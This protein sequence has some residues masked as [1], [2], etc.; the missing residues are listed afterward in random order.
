MGTN[1]H[2]RP[3]QFFS[4][5]Q[6]DAL[7]APIE[8]AEGLPGSAYA[9]AEFFELEKRELWPKRWVAVAFTNDI[10]EPGS[11]TTAN[12]A[13]VPLILARGLDGIARAFVNICPHRAN[14]LV[15]EPAHG[16]RAITCGW[17]CWTFDLEGKFIAAPRAKGQ[18]DAPTICSPPPALKAVRATEWLGTIFVNLGGNAPD[19]EK[20][21]EAL[22]T[23]YRAWRSL[24]ELVQVAEVEKTWNANWKLWVEGGIEDYHLQFVHPQLLRDAKDFDSKPHKLGD[25]FFGLLSKQTKRLNPAD[26]PP[27]PLPEF[28][29]MPAEARSAGGFFVMFPNFGMNIRTTY[30][31]VYFLTPEAPDRTRGR[32]QLLALPEALGDARYQ[33][34]VDRLRGMWTR[35]WDEDAPICAAVQKSAEIRDRVGSPTRFV[36]GWEDSVRNF[37]LK[38]V[39]TIN[40]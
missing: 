9:S 14:R 1:G 38:V 19:L 33:P 7:S 20:Q 10:L 26:I 11:L 13:D 2:N 28:P 25:D 17:H 29:G 32:S 37:Q 23:H 6:L 34:M 36:A 5:E 40:S 39:E 35:V 27:E 24:G 12:V 16:K 15:T 31:R 4:R 8:Q 21:S 18:P 22:Y 3:V 30:I